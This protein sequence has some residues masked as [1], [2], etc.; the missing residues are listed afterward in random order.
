M[1]SRVVGLLELQISVRVIVTSLAEKERLPFL[2]HLVVC[3][4]I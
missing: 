4:F 2:W 1:V 3:R